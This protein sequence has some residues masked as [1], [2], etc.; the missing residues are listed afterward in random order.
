VDD[1]WA[2]RWRLEGELARGACGIVYRGTDLELDRPVAVKVLK[3]SEAGPIARE[4]FLREARIT[5]RLDHPNVVRVLAAGEH[6]GRP[7][8]VMPLLDG[9]PPRGPLPCREAC[10]LVARLASA[11]AHAHARGVSHRDLKPGNVLLCDGEPV[12]TDFGV[13]GDAAAGPLTGT[14]ELVGTPAYMSPEQIEPGKAELG[15]AADVWALGVLLYEL[16]AG[17][18]PFDASSFHAL[19]TS[20]LEDPAPPLPGASRELHDLLRRCLAKRPAE[21]PSAA[22]VARRL[23]RPPRRPALPGLLAAAALL[24]LLGGA[25]GGGAAAP[26]GPMVRVE[27]PEG[28]FWIDLDE[29]PARSAG[30]SYPE[31]LRWCLA[32]GKRLPTEAEWEAAAAAGAG[33]D[34]DG[35]TAEWTATEGAE[36]DTRVVRGGHWRLPPGEASAAAREEVPLVRR[37]PTLG[38]RCARSAQSLR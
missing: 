36:E 16:H 33:R 10:A 9:R 34:L 21:R 20:I 37:R 2:G 19:S 8:Y 28:E 26:T 24:A 7:F 3:P 27:G 15:P 17:R 22:E 14:G 13:A 31:A 6:E 25:A 4:R 11:L 23:S 1:V 32:R 5:A 30:W 18:L 12:L 35:R 29:A 38:V